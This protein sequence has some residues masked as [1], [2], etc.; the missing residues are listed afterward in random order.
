MNKLKY[1]LF[2]IVI[3][4]FAS[5]NQ[6]NDKRIEVKYFPESIDLT[7][8]LIGKIQPQHVKMLRI[9]DSVLIIV[10]RQGN[11][12][13]EYYNCSNL[14]LIGKYGNKGR[15]PGEFISPIPSGEFFKRTKSGPVI[16]VYDWIRR[17]INYINLRES[18]H[19][20]LYTCKSEKLP[21]DLKNI[22]KIIF[23]NDS[24][25]ILIPDNEEKSRFVIYDKESN[26]INYIPFIPKL[27]KEGIHK[28]NQYYVYAPYGNCVSVK[29]QY[30][31]AFPACNGQMDFFDF[32]G[33]Y[34][35]TV[36]L[37]D[38]KYLKAAEYGRDVQ[39]VEGFNVFYSDLQI[40]NDEIYVLFTIYQLPD[41]SVI[42][43]SKIYVF[44]LE[45]H[46][47][48]EYI[49]DKEIRYF[50]VDTINRRFIGYIENAGQLATFKYK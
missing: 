32:S 46:P 41:L 48:K 23:D 31:I 35:K 13:F 22:Y 33:N 50:A 30:F 21:N 19:N 29:R 12:F 42:G 49:L 16:H 4:L 9:I 17:R 3:F 8:K 38:N 44:D 7:G 36:H 40:I 28:N 43:K 6:V 47:K 25:V 15:G 5:C 2:G 10:N 27:T 20:K 24:I 26:S 37:V 1:L 14:D 34:L 45:G 39:L 11:Y 18:I